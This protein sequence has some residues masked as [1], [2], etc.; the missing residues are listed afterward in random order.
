MPAAYSM[1]LRERVAALF[2]EGREP[3]EISR[4]MKLGVATVGRWKRALRERG[5]VE[6]LPLPGGGEEKLGIEGKEFLLNLVEQCPDATLADMVDTL[7]EHRG[8]E[9]TVST[10]SALL[11]KLGYSWKKKTFRLKEQDAAALL[12]MQKTFVA[13]LAGK[14]PEKIV[15]LDECGAN[16]AMTPTHARSLAGERAYAPRPTRRGEKGIHHRRAHR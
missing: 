15:F 14:D 13:D 2:D 16:E 4:L 3:L 11:V 8:I 7:R 9:V 10:V 12:E 5:G 6:P 1:E